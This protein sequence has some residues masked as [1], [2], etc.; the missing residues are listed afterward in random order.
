MKNDLQRSK[1]S[2]SEIESNRHKRVSFI[3]LIVVCVL[4]FFPFLYVLGMSFRTTDDLVLHPSS[5]FPHK[6]GWT[7]E[8]YSNFFKLNDGKMDT[9]MYAIINSTITTVIHVVVSL[10]LTVFAAYSFVFMRYKGRAFIYSVIIATM[11][12][13]GVI[14]FAPQYSM[15][16]S[17]GKKADILD[18]LIYFYSWLIF[19]GVSGAFNLMIMVNCFKSIPKELVESARADGATELKSFKRVVVP[20]AKSSMLVCALFSFNGCWNNL[21]FPQ[22][23]IASQSDTKVHTTITVMLMGWIGNDSVEF[24]GVGMASCVISIVP[25]MIMYIISQNKM[26][27]GLASTGVKG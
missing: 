20:L 17:I 16:I 3:I 9:M 2:K 27:D 5:F 24:K 22:L 26:I 6:N 18:N 11:A 4:W 21:L 23:V 25:L 7:L 15:F 14:G 1:L 10:V 19:P 12:I 13:P 8:N